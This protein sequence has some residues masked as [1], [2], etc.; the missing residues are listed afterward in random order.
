M[1][2]GRASTSLVAPLLAASL[3]GCGGTYAKVLAIT[4]PHHPASIAPLPSAE[5]FEERCPAGTQ[6]KVEDFDGNDVLHF[7]RYC[8]GA[9]DHTEGPFL[10]GDYIAGRLRVASGS[11]HDTMLDSRWFVFEGTPAT[12]RWCET[13]FAEQHPVGHV[14][15]GWDGTRTEGDFDERGRMHGAWMIDDKAYSFDHG[16]GEAGFYDVADGEVKGRCVDGLR[17]GPWQMANRGQVV[18]VTYARGMPSGPAC[19]RSGGELT[20]EGELRDGV[21]MTWRGWAKEACFGDEPPR[22]TPI[23]PARGPAEGCLWSCTFEAGRCRV[24]QRETRQGPARLVS[25]G[26]RRL[27]GAEAGELISYLPA[28]VLHKEPRRCPMPRVLWLG[29]G[30]IPHRG[31]R[32]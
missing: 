5:S 9:S 23:D 22:E 20:G 11:L 14:R 15:G 17:D 25:L 4:G 13:T 31:S 6:Y 10:S 19:T 8:A 29:D 27:E 32:R 16:T 12:N 21:L 30:L 1:H 18:E 28:H 26:R 7:Q 2:P 24:A 3:A